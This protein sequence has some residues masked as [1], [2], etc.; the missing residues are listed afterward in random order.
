M[1]LC[2]DMKVMAHES[3]H[4]THISFQID[5]PQVPLRPLLHTPYAAMSGQIKL[6]YI[7]KGEKSGKG[8]GE[9]GRGDIVLVPLFLTLPHDIATAPFDFGTVDHRR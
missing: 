6:L 7:F 4:V 3:P 8:G 5:V 2:V 9:W 1:R